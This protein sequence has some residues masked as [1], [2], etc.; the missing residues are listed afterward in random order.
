MKARETQEQDFLIEQHLINLEILD[1]DGGRRQVQI[2]VIHF[3]PK[4]HHIFVIHESCLY[5]PRRQHQVQGG[6]R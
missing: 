4:I 3:P 6:G 1:L 5:H 2:Q